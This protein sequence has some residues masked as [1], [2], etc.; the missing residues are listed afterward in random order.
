MQVGARVW[1]EL[2]YRIRLSTTFGYLPGPYV[3]TINAVLVAVDAY[4][5]DTADLIKAALKNSFVF[6][7][8]GGWRP[9]RKR[10]AYFEVGYA[11]VSLGGSLTPPETLGG[12]TMRQAPCELNT[13]CGYNVNALLHMVD[14]ELGWQWIV[15][16]GLTFRL[17]FGAAL[18]V[19]SQ[20]KIEAQF[21][22]RLPGAQEQFTAAGEAYLNDTFRSYVFTP[23]ISFAVGWRFLPWLERRW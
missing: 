16:K 14:V 13:S 2:P 3:D 6:R 20:T 18:T 12:A 23:T 11:L 15:S 7:A 21:T 19:W 5:Q 10:G 9:W 22:P 4:N 8:H 1:L 17:A